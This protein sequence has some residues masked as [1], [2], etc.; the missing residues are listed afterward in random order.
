MDGHTRRGASHQVST[1]PRLEFLGR[2]E[3]RSNVDQL[4]SEHE[5]LPG[6]DLRVVPAPHSSIRCLPADTQPVNANTYQLV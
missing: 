1:H 4:P 5:L 6:D 3:S 2:Q